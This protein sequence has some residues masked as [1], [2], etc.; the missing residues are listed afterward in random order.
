[1][2]FDDL[3]FL[4]RP[5]D[6]QFTAVVFEAGLDWR[7]PPFDLDGDVLIFGRGALPSGIPRL[8]A[9]RASVARETALMRL[10]LHPPARW[11]VL[12]V[13]RIS[14]PTLTVPGVREQ[15]R[16]RVLGGAIV[17][18]ERRRS[19]PRVLDVVAAAAG[20]GR[21]ASSVRLH[22]NGSGLG[23]VQVKGQP[24][25]MLRLGRL[26]TGADPETNANALE[27]LSS[28]SERLIP[29]LFARGSAAGASWCTEERLPG[30]RP[31]RVDQRVG[32][33]VCGFLGRL[34]HSNGPPTSLVDD[35]SSIR[36]ALPGMAGDIER[37]GRWIG[38][39]ERMPAI[40]RHGDLWR[41]N[42][43]QSKGRLTGVV[44]WDNWHPAAV[45]GTD[46]LH[47]VAMEIGHG[48]RRSLGHVWLDRPW[49]SDEYR[50]LSDGYWRALGYSPDQEDLLTVGVAWWACQVAGSLHRLPELA[51]DPAWLRANVEPV[52]GQLGT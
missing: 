7:L 45:P 19:G 38:L 16:R 33:D 24:M 9:V 18:T 15:V 5:A 26:G 34:P 1:M 23:P 46:L 27:Q 41:G 42:L 3:A 49:R 10:R 2:S 21:W 6:A 37:W 14:P 35:L 48:S 25:A 47:L 22:S 12:A 43:L 36:T 29:R 28:R 44:D 40:S 52:V 13:H 39:A 31:R 51:V 17:E 11:R 4:L 20:V 30:S 8:R 50:R 32:A